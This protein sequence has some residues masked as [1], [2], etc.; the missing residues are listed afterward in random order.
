MIGFGSLFTLISESFPTE[1]KGVGMAFITFCGRLG[2]ITSPIV[3][4]WLLGL[5]NGF[6]LCIAV[7]AIIYAAIALVILFVKETKC[8]A[9]TKLLA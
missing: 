5:I 4:G 1:I 6:E 8:K 3:T 9:S 2:G 7:Y